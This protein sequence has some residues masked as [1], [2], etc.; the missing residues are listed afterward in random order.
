M[1]VDKRMDDGPTLEHGY[2]IS[3]PYEPNGPD[4]LQMYLRSVSSNDRIKHIIVKDMI[5][6]R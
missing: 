3:S 5:Q 6:P 1:V 4:E 2:I